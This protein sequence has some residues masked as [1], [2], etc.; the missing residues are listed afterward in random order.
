MVQTLFILLKIHISASNLYIC[1][2]RV[3]CSVWVSVRN[4]GARLPVEKADNKIMTAN[5]NYFPNSSMN[6][7]RQTTEMKPIRA[8]LYSEKRV[9][10]ILPWQPKT[11]IKLKWTNLCRSN[12]IFSL[13]LTF[14]PQLN[15]TR[16]CLAWQ[17]GSYDLINLC[18]FS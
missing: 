18:S 17:R 5:I 15:L 11:G 16:L 12:A 6:F 8:L 7:W 13:F 10:V 3:P 9:V 14:F 4:C 2:M 1:C